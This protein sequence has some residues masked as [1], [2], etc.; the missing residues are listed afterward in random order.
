MATSS[1]V[2]ARRPQSRFKYALFSLLGLMFLFVLWNNEGFII[3]HA[4][5]D[6]TY[7]F[8]VRYLL[9]PHGLGGLTALLI[10]PLQLSSRFRT[11]HVRVHRILGGF[12][13]GGIT[14]AATM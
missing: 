9:I 3:D 13:I 14:L 10:G 8:P 12:Y 4:H 5:P 6:W 11:K 7:Y 2:V 1:A